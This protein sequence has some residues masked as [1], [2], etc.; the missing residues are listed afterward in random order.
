MKTTTYTTPKV[1]PQVLTQTNWTPSEEA[2]KAMNRLVRGE[3]S[4]VEAYES[5]IDKIDS[6]PELERLNEMLKNHR[7]NVTYF[8]KMALKQNE[9]P[10]YDS[11][12]WGTVV[13]LFV[14]SAKL[15]GNTAALKS[16]KE[17]E[18]HGLKEY[19]KLL[20]NDEVPMHVKSYVRDKIMPTLHMNIN[21]ISAMMKIQ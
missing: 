3:I 10:E 15:F 12:I 4:A 17:G 8:K 13:S 16:L 14:G 20:E 18:E 1:K 7:S 2:G 9:L 19:Q 11:G 5:I 6:K 21:S